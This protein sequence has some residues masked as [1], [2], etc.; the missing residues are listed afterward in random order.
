MK[1]TIQQK[2][3]KKVLLSGIVVAGLSVLSLSAQTGYLGVTGGVQYTTIS[4]SAETFNGGIGYNFGITAE[5]RFS[6][7]FGLE[8][9]AGLSALNAST[10]YKDSIQY[11]D[12]VERYTNN[13]TFNSMYLHGQLLAK[14]YI[15][16]GGEPITPYDRPT[17][18]GN[19]LYFFAGPYAG[20]IAGSGNLTKIGR[21]GT[22]IQKK[23]I[24]NSVPWDSSAL[25]TKVTLIDDDVQEANDR[26]A[27]T[28]LDLGITAGVGV[29]LRLN[30]FASLDFSLRYM[31][32]L[33]TID[34][35]N[36]GYDIL[37][38]N[39]FWLGHANLT[40]TST[41]KESAIAYNPANALNTFIAFNV[42]LTYKI[43]GDS[44]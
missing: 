1:R 23:H 37:T 35:P 29:S 11:Y 32:S 15:R 22:Q 36:E 41:G 8:L 38:K 14:Y 12:Y 16:L 5:N 10:N 17:G 6:Q 18:S 9:R 40:F 24:N 34:Q 13:Y 27:L 43:Y 30:T 19:Y 42:G 39:G 3:G 4:S 21:T 7:K 31:G 20:Y 2:F 26:N 28:N 44:Y 25:T 33:M